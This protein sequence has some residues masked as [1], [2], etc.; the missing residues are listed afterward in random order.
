MTRN[1][2]HIERG[3]H[4]LLLLTL[5]HSFTY[6]P[7]LEATPTLMGSNAFRSHKSDHGL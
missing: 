4:R 6:V 2:E 1:T 5:R 3:T 7:A